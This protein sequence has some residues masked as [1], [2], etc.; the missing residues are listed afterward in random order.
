ML[1]G[2]QLV[3][4]P[5]QRRIAPQLMLL[6]EESRVLAARAVHG[7][8]RAHHHVPDARRRGGR[9]Q[10]QRADRL[11]L[12]ALAPVAPRV[13]EEGGVDDRGHL[14]LLERV[15]QGL[16]GRGRAEVQRAMAHPQRGRRRGNVEGQDGVA[17]A[18]RG[19]PPQDP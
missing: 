17:A 9:Q 11:Q 2:L 3:A 6:A 7:G 12:V 13:G 1:L 14:V 16:V 15:E 5:G 19:Q 4:H 8:E 10:P 18:A